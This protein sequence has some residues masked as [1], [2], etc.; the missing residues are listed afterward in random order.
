MR[1]YIYIHMHTH[2]HTIDVTVDLITG[3]A[4]VV[5]FVFVSV[6]RLESKIRLAVLSVADLIVVL[7]ETLRL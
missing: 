4:V 5:H 6:A 7:A 3:A 2:T 1:V